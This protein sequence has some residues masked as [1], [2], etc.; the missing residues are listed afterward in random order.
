MLSIFVSKAATSIKRIKPDNC[1]RTGSVL[2]SIGSRTQFWSEST[3]PAC[4]DYCCGMHITSTS[5]S[6]LSVP[7][8][9]SIS[10]I[11]LRKPSGSLFGTTRDRFDPTQ[12]TFTAAMLGLS[13]DPVMFQAVSAASKNE[14]TVL[15][16]DAG[17]KVAPSV[18]SDRKKLKPIATVEGVDGL[19]GVDEEV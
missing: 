3:V 9:F 1:R 8:A 11:I 4:V 2:F 19:T 7:A 15:Q 5:T 12:E 16:A 13:F 14:S 6:P 17:L 18:G 10:N